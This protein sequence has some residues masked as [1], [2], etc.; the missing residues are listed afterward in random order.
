MKVYSIYWSFE[1][2]T[3]FID[4]NAFDTK[5]SAVEAVQSK[6]VIHKQDDNIFISAGGH[7]KAEIIE[8]VVLRGLPT[9]NGMHFSPLE[10]IDTKDGTMIR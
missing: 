6:G 1:N 9:K 2:G 5:N 7:I 3:S 10:I 8:Q 4:D